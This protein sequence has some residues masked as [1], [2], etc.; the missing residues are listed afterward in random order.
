MERKIKLADGT[1]K[2]VSAD[3]VLQKGEEEV[4]SEEKALLGKIKEVVET[5]IDAKLAAQKKD[6]LVSNANNNQSQNKAFDL[7]SK[8]QKHNY[9]LMDDKS[10]KEYESKVIIA[11]YFKALFN[12]DVAMIKALSEGTGSAGGYLVPS[13][14][15]SKIY[16]IV[17]ATGAARRE[18][19]VI[20]MTSMTLDLSTLATKP[21]IYYVGEGNQITAS[22]LVFGRKTLT[23]EKMAGITAMSNELI[24][25]AN[26]DL[27]NFNVQ[28][29]AEAFALEE[30]KAF[31]NTSTATGIK[32]LLE[33]TTTQVVMTSGD[34]DFT[35]ISYSYLIDVVYSIGANQRIG[36]KWCFSSYIMSLI[37]KLKDLQNMPIWSRAIEG[38]P[39]TLL[40][41]PIIENDQ[42]PQFADN[43]VS[44]KCLIFGNFTKY[45]I[46]DRKQMT[47]T[48]LREGTIGSTNLAEKDSSGIRV[49]QR[50]SGVAPNPLEFA[51]LKTA[52]S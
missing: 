26:I 5:T 13:V 8:T 36:A 18:M 50:V 21:V 4:I 23:A 40:G 3:Y 45:I 46:G 38:Q 15:S 37:M 12:K 14:L 49:V 22:D 9:S 10:K 2:I 43:G 52:A 1:I 39:A 17:L 7:M 16:E 42:M 30:D 33:D 34:T 20:P 25:D 48:V 31:F 11:N 6:L 29:F 27:I 51:T 19:T 32:G 28:K 47:A 41:Y 35:D 44:K 24:D